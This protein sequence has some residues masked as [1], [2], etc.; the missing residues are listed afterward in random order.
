MD[1]GNSHG[2]LDNHLLG[3]WGLAWSPDG[4]TLAVWT[5]DEAKL[6]DLSTGQP[7]RTL[8][9]QGV[10]GLAWSPDGKALAV[11]TRDEAKLWD[12]ST[13][14]PPRTLGLQGV[15]GMAWSPDGKTLAVWTRDEAKLWDLS[16]GQPLR[17]L[18]CDQERQGS[19][20]QGVAWSLDSKFLAGLCNVEGKKSVVQIWH[21]GT[22]EK[23]RTLR[24][25]PGDISSVEW[26][27]DGE[28]IAF[29][30]E[31]EI[32]LWHVTTGKDQ[33]RKP[34]GHKDTI[35]SLAWSPVPLGAFSSGHPLERMV[36]IF[37][38]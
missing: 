8:G 31:G 14:Q 20:Q 2:T 27:P 10:M 38:K 30:L 5:R 28:H 9:L 15:M 13:G 18:G 24:N 37:G 21:A 3:E 19:L 11:W 35:Y 33:L 36:A 25:S 23:L 16:T 17:A 22:G 1:T 7:P 4:K 29:I 12:L 32:Q 34:N 26:S 6:W